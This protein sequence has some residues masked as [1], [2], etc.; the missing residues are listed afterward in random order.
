M[1]EEKK[2]IKETI[3]AI[4]ALGELAS[5][6]T[7]LVSVVKDILKDGITIS[8]VTKLG[9]LVD[10]APDMKVLEAGIEDIK[11]ALEE[12]KDLD[13][14]EIIQIISAIYK[15]IANFKK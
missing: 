13:E 7:K 2:G 14:A 3:E 4:E 9:D 6:G 15:I 10:A 12:V 1:L 8:D 5:S 11:L